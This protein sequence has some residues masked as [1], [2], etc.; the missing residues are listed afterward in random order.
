MVKQVLRFLRV[1]KNLIREMMFIVENF[2][3]IY[4]V[5]QVTNLRWNN[6]GF[7][8]KLDRETMAFYRQAKCIK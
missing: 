2:V 1:V 5:E 3:G 7:Y 4:R 6:L 8:R